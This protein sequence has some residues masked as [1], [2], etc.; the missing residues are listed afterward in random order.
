MNKNNTEIP[1]EAAYEVGY[2]DGLKCGKLC[3]TQQILDELEELCLQKKDEYRKNVT[4]HPE[5]EYPEANAYWTG[6]SVS[7]FEV[8]Q[9]IKK[10]KT[11]YGVQK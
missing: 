10:L 3:A 2:Q 8:L 9:Q 5:V 7:C 1:R 4:D 11:K 6:R